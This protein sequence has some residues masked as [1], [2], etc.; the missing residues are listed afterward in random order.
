M[1]DR[2]PA[3]LPICQN[4]DV[5][6]TELHR[7]NR[8]AV[9]RGNGKIWEMH[10]VE[11][12][13]RDDATQSQSAAGAQNIYNFSTLLNASCTGGMGGCALQTSQSVP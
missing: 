7:Y 4:R 8:S 10:A 1:F 6:S 2:T 9:W 13:H 5:L 12:S 11:L 3:R